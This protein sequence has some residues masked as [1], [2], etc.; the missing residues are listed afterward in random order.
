MPPNL[1]SLLLASMG[2]GQPM[3]FP[4]QL[5]GAY[6]GMQSSGAGY[7]GPMA[8]TGNMQPLA[9]PEL[10]QQFQQVSAVP[11]VQQSSCPAGN[12]PPLSVYAMS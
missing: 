5:H 9:P 7:L 11:T 12:T 3:P 4:P 6:P 10:I 2:A 1:Y 8:S